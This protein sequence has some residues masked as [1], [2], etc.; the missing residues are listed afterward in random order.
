MDPKGLIITMMP[1]KGCNDR[2]DAIISQI[3]VVLHH[4][5]S[6]LGGTE[7]PILCA[8]ICIEGYFGSHIRETLVYK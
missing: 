6:L 4:L 2:W 7:L 3:G 1:M 5:R 8:F